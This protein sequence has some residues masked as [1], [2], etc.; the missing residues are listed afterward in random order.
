MKTRRLVAGAM[1]IALAV[2]M[3]STTAFA[4]SVKFTDVPDSHWASSSITEMADKGIMS[5]IGNNLFAPSQQLS[6]AE[7]ITMLVRQFYS[8]KL[9]AEGSTWYAPFMAAAKSANILTGTNVGSNEDLATS[10]INRYDMAQLMYNVLKAEGITTS[11]LSDTSKVAD[12]SA[13]PSTYRD[14]VSV[15]YNMGMLTGVDNKGTFN[16]TGVMDRAQAAVVMDRLLEVCS[17]GTPSTPEKPAGSTSITKLDQTSGYDGAVEVEGGFFFDSTKVGMACSRLGLNTVGYNK[18]SFTIKATDTDVQVSATHA[19]EGVGMFDPNKSYRELLGV[20][21]AGSS[22][23]FTID[24][25]ADEVV[26]IVPADAG[27]INELGFSD[28][29]VECYLLDLTIS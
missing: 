12:W 18:I 17:G 3:F 9:G 5:G 22:K 21:Q 29:F 26:G 7:F 20:V 1:S 25:S 2:T 15:C 16:G 14:A 24:C 8:D 6:N 23:S 27:H 13:V 4:A 28:I 19:R 11:S 10:T